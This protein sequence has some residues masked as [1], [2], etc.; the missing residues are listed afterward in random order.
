MFLRQ[1]FIQQLRSRV[2]NGWWG[3]IISD[4]V[5]NPCGGSVIVVCLLRKLVEKHSIGRLDLFQ[6]IVFRFIGH[7]QVTT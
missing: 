6:D 4:Y 1:R 2:G 7:R 5:E 3:D